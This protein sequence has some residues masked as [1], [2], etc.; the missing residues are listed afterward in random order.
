MNVVLLSIVLAGLLS[1]APPVDFTGKW[2]RQEAGKRQS[3]SGPR[4]LVLS[5]RHREP[6]F[7]Y[8]AEGIV[9]IDSPFVEEL[10]FST[11]GQASAEPG[12]L[13][14]AGVWE[15]SEL[16]VRYRKDGRHVGVIRM[17]LSGD[18]KRL[19]RVISL[20]SRPAFTEIYDRE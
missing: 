5:I 6:L 19:T 1:G 15:G 14:A 10:E 18:G 16:V 9:G 2:K 3:L 20:G 17:S 4:D 11:A 13:T 8:R 12:K 7:H